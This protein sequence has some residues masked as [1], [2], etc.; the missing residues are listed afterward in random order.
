MPKRHSTGARVAKRLI[1]VVA[2]AAALVLLA[3]LIAGVALAVRVK[4]GG[5]VLFR[6][7]RPG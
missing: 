2:A 3:P 5:P 4:L 1:D 7:E 6:Q